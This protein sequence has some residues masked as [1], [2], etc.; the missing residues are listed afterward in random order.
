[1]FLT[2]FMLFLLLLPQGGEVEAAPSGEALQPGGLEAGVAG[3]EEGGAPAALETKQEYLD[4]GGQMM[5]GVSGVLLSRDSCSATASRQVP[6]K[7]RAYDIRCD[8]AQL[9]LCCSDA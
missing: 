9:Q 8:D 7:G 4:Q 6:G 2:R 3:G 5:Y 1:M